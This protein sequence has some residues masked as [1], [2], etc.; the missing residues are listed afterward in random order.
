MTGL[1]VS[2]RS[3]AEASIALVAGADLIDVK[4]P[5]RGPLGAADATVWS[6]V[7]HSVGRTKPVSVALGEL[8]E[9]EEIPMQSLTGVSY[10]KVG[11]AGC[12]HEPNWFKRWSNAIRS[13]PNG[14]MPVAVAYADWL[15][16]D[17]PPATVVLQRAKAAG[18][19]AILMDTFDKTAGSL[20]DYWSL[21]ALSRWVASAQEK[22][23]TV[24]LAGSLDE[25]S[26]PLVLRSAPDYIGV[27]GAACRNGRK[28]A[29]DQTRV[30]NLA[31]SLTL[32][33]TVCK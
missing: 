9:L 16:A 12:R 4:E 13:L 27:R 33:P 5:E 23:L 22:G 19:G 7:C 25:Q 31:A 28:N 11:L 21:V 30:S 1:L 20:L 32:K 8:L 17:S 24:V 29:I 10:A 26:I 3:V 15:K 2:V 6:A 18:C 14:V